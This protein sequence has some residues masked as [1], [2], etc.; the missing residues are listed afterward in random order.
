MPLSNNSVVLVCFS[1]VVGLEYLLFTVVVSGGLSV[2]EGIV[3]SSVLV[4]REV[5]ED[6]ILSSVVL[7]RSVS[8]VDEAMVVISSVAVVVGVAEVVG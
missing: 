4:G 2:R 5:K 6:I 7:S 3:S 1:V 8:V